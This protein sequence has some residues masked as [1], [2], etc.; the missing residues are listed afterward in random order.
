LNFITKNLESLFTSFMNSIQIHH[1]HGLSVFRPEAF[2]GLEI[3]NSKT[4]YAL[5][6]DS[7]A[8]GAVTAFRLSP[9]TVKRLLSSLDKSTTLSKQASTLFCSIADGYGPLVAIEVVAIPVGSRTC[10][11]TT[12]KSE[13]PGMDHEDFTPLPSFST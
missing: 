6:S 9:G 4:V 10:L 11:G 1:P 7:V 2:V 12:P 13:P 8:G 5:F 3:P